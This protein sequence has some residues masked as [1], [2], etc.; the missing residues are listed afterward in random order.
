MIGCVEDAELIHEYSIDGLLPLDWT[1]AG[2]GSARI[3][4]VSPDG[5]V[6]KV[7]ISPE[8][9]NS[10]EF[11][12]INRIRK[13]EKLKGWDV[14]EASLYV[15]DF[16]VSVIA[17]EFVSGVPDIECDAASIFADECTC[18]QKPCIAYVWDVAREFWGIHDLHLD[19]IKV[20]PDGVRVIIDLE[21]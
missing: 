21:A 3:A 14:P 18:G 13:G 1:I 9:S 6:Y 19:N 2:E 15:L 4:Y 10:H 7:E 5:I 8:G 11:L 16:D 20:R 17:M 12:N